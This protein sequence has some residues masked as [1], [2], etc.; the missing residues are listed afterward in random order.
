[1][2]KTQLNIIHNSPGLETVPQQHTSR[3]QISKTDMDLIYSTFEFRIR[4]VPIFII[5]FGQY[6]FNKALKI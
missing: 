2:C 5:F 3:A 4:T 1:M 6:S